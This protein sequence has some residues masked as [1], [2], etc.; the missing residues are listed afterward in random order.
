MKKPDLLV[1][2]AIWEFISAFVAFIGI[3]AIA[4]FAIAVFAIPFVLGSWGNWEYYNGD[5]YGMMGNYTDM[6]R[7]GAVFGLSVAIL[8]LLCFLVIAVV[9]GIG[10]LKGRE[11][12]RI[13]GIVH[14][15]LSVFC[16]PIGTVIGVFS[17]IYLTKQ[18]VKDF[19]IP[20]AKV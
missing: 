9:A 20:P 5:Y 2:I 1:L 19:F 12:G 11:W 7:V 4:V 3:V 17:I 13:T 10:L 8:I 16:A 15:A 6:P 18:E 14:S